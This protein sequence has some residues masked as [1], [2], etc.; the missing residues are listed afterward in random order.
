MNALVGASI[1]SDNTAQIEKGLCAEKGLV[2]KQ[3]WRWSIH[4]QG[5]DLRFSLA[6]LQSSLLTNLAETAYFL[7]HT[8]ADAC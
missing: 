8:C 2:F 3:D 5:H 1:V 6:D 7:L 4:I